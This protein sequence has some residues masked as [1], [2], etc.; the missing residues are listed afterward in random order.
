MRDE[1]SEGWELKEFFD[2]LNE[3]MKIKESVDI[4]HLLHPY[5]STHF[6]ILPSF[7]KLYSY[8]SEEVKRE[9]SEFDFKIIFRTFGVD[10]RAIYDEFSEFLHGRHPLF[11]N[12]FPEEKLHEHLYGNCGNFLRNK[13]DR[14]GIVLISGM[15]PNKGILSGAKE[16]IFDHHTPK[17][18]LIN[19]L[20]DELEKH[21]YEYYNKDVLAIHRGIKEIHE[22]LL[23]NKDHFM[24][25]QDDYETWHYRDEKNPFAKP[26]VVDRENASEVYQIFF[27][28]HCNPYDDCI[29]NAIDLHTGE[30]IPYEDH[31]DRYSVKA[32]PFSGR[33]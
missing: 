11:E 33:Y 27:D 22:F 25:I 7:F 13:D 30:T 15:F 23:S 16:F 24:C 18:E 12:L 4:E 29:V 8:L 1:T 19:S 17:E 5:L 32:D 20:I 9:S 3:K 26:M 21:N 2:D 31:I 14:L 10:H 28:D 6:S